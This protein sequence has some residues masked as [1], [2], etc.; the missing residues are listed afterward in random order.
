MSLEAQVVGLPT[1]VRALH[2]ADVG[3]VTGHPLV[4]ALLGVNIRVI[5][6][7]PRRFLVGLID[8]DAAEVIVALLVFVLVVDLIL[9]GFRSVLVVFP[10][11]VFV[12]RRFLL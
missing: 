9:R 12:P 3:R 4:L 6:S 5:V 2:G 8:F 7:V 1:F 11:R 10:L